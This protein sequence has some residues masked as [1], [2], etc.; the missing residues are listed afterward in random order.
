MRVIL[1]SKSPRRKELMDLL[2][3]EYEIIESSGK[4]IYNKELTIEEQSKQIAKAKV[5]EVFDK[6]EGD[7]IVVGADTL[8]IK[9]SKIYGKPKD[10]KEATQMIRDLSGDKHQ[11]IT[12]YAVSIR[13]QDKTEEH[14]GNS[15][16]DVYLKKISDEEIEK[17]L[18]TGKYMDRAGAY[19]IQDEFAVHVEKIEGSYSS[20][21]GLPIENIYDCIKG[22]I[23]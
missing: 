4:E 1:A 23:N 11:V 7:R 2:N 6:A 20:I 16:S 3:I 15:I 14:I 9:D 18:K 19:G 10:R 17:W 8:V 22:Y 21:V 13:I 5:K 12:S